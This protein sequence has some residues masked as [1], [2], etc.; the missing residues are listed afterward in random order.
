M[1]SVVVAKSKETLSLAEY[2]ALEAASE[3]KHDFVNGEVYARSG[4]TPEHSALAVAFGAELRA[5]LAGKPCSPFSSDA[6]V[7]VE[8]TGSSF[9]P[10]LSVVCGKVEPAAGDGDAIT[11][12]VVLVEVLSESTE[13]Y[14]RGAKAGHYRR[15]A[16]LKE[17]VLVSQAERRIEVQRLN[18]RGVWEL[19]FFGPG[20]RVELASLG[21]SVALDAVY[22]NPRRLA[23]HLVAAEP[24]PC[25]SGRIGSAPVKRASASSARA[26]SAFR[27]RW[28]SARPASR[29]WASTSTR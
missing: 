9:Y 17:Y 13:A 10:D 28:C 4:G 14:D 2:L 22:A 3:V 12:P 19:H 5:A 18:E 8:S 24:S 1:L 23:V 29:W 11:N 6:R 25:C 26:T 27:W 7:R 20:E 16:S 15:L 21:V